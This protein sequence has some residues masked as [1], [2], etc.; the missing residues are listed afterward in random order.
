MTI[1]QLAEVESLCVYNEHGAVNFIGK[2]D[3]IGLDLADLITITPKSV[4]VYDD[5]RHA[6]P[7]VG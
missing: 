2:T 7:P 4:E 1:K 5:T 6:K 3:V